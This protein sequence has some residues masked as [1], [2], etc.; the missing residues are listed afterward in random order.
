MQFNATV[1]KALKLSDFFKEDFSIVTLATPDRD[2]K[3]FKYPLCETNP[4]TSIFVLFL[5][6]LARCESVIDT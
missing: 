6:L 5:E 4:F 3:H 2:L 1:A